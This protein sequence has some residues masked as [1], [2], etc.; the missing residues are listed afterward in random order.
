LRRAKERIR[1]GSELFATPGLLYFLRD[2]S[3]DGIGD[4]PGE[5]L[6]HYAALDDDDVSVSIKMWMSDNDPILSRLAGN[7]VNRHL[8]RIKIQN[9]PFDRF[10]IEELKNLMACK[11]AFNEDQTDYFIRTGTLSN[12][13]YNSGNSDENILV[14][15]NGESVDIT[16]ASDLDN[17][18]GMSK[19]VEKHF[20]CYPK[21]IDL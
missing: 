8:F 11:Y 3:P 2:F 7:L 20:L 19:V 5:T 16:E 1:S 15:Q 9:E 13:A 10:R 17:L 12:H 21:E 6:K 18:F 4:N 14:M